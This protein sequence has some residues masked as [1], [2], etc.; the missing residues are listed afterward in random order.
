MRRTLI[1]V[2][3]LVAF[4]T[5]SIVAG[6]PDLQAL[7][8]GGGA[9]PAGAPGPGAAGPAGQDAG[10][11]GGRAGG[12]GGRGGAPA[13]PP[14][15]AQASATVDLIGYWV[16]LV[17]EDWRWRMKVPMKG[18]VS[19][20]P[21]TQAA[22]EA[23]GAWDPAKD[24][25]EGNQC[26]AYG[27]AAIMR[28][29]TRVHITWQDPNTLKLET[30][31]GMQTRLFRFEE[32]AANAP[33]GERTWQ[34]VSVA[35]WEPQPGGG[36]GG[37]GG[38]GGPLPGGAAGPPPVR[39]GGPGGAA[40]GP[41]GGRGV[42]PSPA[43]DDAA[44]PPGG[45]GGTPQGPAVRGALK[46]VTTNM[47]PGYLRKNGVPYG[48]KA[49]VTEYFHRTP[50]TYGITYMI[51]TTVVEDPEHLTGPFITSSHFRKLP[52]TANGWDPTPCS[53]T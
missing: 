16:S 36:R 42:V 53:V 2:V 7:G 10:G 23:A 6:P 26:K 15:T 20:I 17:T 32:A 1:R 11:R 46:V 40:P 38:R 45:R 28:V 30:D 31:A 18:D 8:Q 25:A 44:P 33:P 14:P 19:S 27:A 43:D 12:R 50:E 48:E 3:G 34:G 47:K 21:V 41:A 9:A 51:V 24:E 29:P 39:A 35:E 49:V 22:R 4:M 52:D 37:R 13:G 5:G